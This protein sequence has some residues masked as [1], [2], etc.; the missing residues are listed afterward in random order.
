MNIEDSIRIAELTVTNTIGNAHRIIVLDTDDTSSSPDGKVKTIEYTDFL[1]VSSN[2]VVTVN[3]ALNFGN[4]AANSF[5]DRSFS[6]SG[7]V[8]GDW[9]VASPRVPLPA[10][11]AIGGAWV[12]SNNIVS[13]RLI[14][15][16]NSLIAVN[17]INFLVNKLQAPS[18]LI[19][20]FT[21]TNIA[22]L[23]L[24]YDFADESTVTTA[25]NQ[26]SQVDDKSINGNNAV[27]V[28]GSSQP[29]YGLTTLNGL[30]TA[31]FD[32][33]KFLTTQNAITIDS[34]ITVFMVVSNINRVGTNANLFRDSG[35]A[36]AVTYIN[37]GS[38]DQY[39]MFNGVTLQS[40]TSAVNDTSV[41]TSVYNGV[42]SELRRN[43][44]QI[45][46]GDTGISSLVN[47]LQIANATTNGQYGEFLY[48]NRVL[49]T[50]EILDI[51]EYLLG[52]WGL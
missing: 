12:G 42:N 45:A 9:V 17:E 15:N 29:L 28:T 49:T 14:N 8:T 51:E 7:L 40:A 33:N 30:N 5:V 18:F 48:Y 35:N 47:T 50:Q 44:T 19:P 21:P 27:Q 6:V 43:G 46:S 10:N 2:D 11:I 36:S 34:N 31:N 20:D 4:I 26:I 25:G 23:S 52:K 1:T 16:S 41:L 22:D 3:V 24:W 38:S 37:Q 32:T 39:A 13:V